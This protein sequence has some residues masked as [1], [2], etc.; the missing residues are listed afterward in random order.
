MSHLLTP[1]PA[2]VVFTLMCAL[3]LGGCASLPG[4]EPGAVKATPEQ[5]SWW[6]AK[7]R[8]HWP[9]G[10]EKPRWFLDAMVAR[11]VVAPLLE[12][13]RDSIE[14]WRFHRRAARDG[15]GH[16]LSFIYYAKPATA[17]AI[18]RSLAGDGVLSELRAAGQLE[19]VMADDVDRMLARGTRRT[20]LGA[21]S[22]RRWQP[23]VQRHWPHFIQGVSRFWLELMNSY[24]FSEAK[25]ERG[26]DA[27]DTARRLEIYR[28]IH[29][30][31]TGFWQGQAR[32]ALLHHLNALFA[33]QPVRV[34]GREGRF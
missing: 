6:Y 30:R 8:F 1:V 21:T 24:W 14:L 29:E 25:D 19:R 23:E 15:G 18:G 11:E 34:R 9:D 7:F 13:H 20:T 32:H 5:A 26:A 3:F 2:G 28:S 4:A 33:Y 12:S 27:P 10:E 16:Q 31:L 22:D 17:R